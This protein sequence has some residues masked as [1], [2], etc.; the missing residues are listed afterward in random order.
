MVQHEASNSFGTV[1]SIKAEALGEPG[2]RT[3]RVLI[4]SGA[5][6]ACLWLEKEQLQ[7]LA[8]Y[9]QE[10][11]EALSQK[12]RESVQGVAEETWSGGIKDIEFKVGRL[13]LGHD[14]STN[15]FLFLAHDV[16]SAEDAPAD[17]SFWVT[18]DMAQGLS[19][20]ALELCAAGRPRCFLCRQP[21][22]PEGHM[23]VRSN[24]H[25]PFQS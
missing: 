9:I 14:T 1:S 23:C 8:I 7:Q 18:L 22:N 15:S 25:Q 17:L 21:I 19:K 20:E 13:A 6:S 2:Q 24:G 12:G 16:E 5:A 3:F 10:A 4:Q 11:G